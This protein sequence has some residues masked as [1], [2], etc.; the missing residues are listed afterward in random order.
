VG[1]ASAIADPDPVAE[2]RR[3]AELEAEQR[4]EN[5]RSPI[6]GKAVAQPA[7]AGLQRDLIPSVGRGDEDLAPK[8][9]SGD[10]EGDCGETQN[11]EAGRPA[12][13]AF[14]E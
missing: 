3:P 4:R 5:E 10:D 2:R 6:T 7:V 14:L 13:G 1:L 11:E 12:H 9:G 8:R